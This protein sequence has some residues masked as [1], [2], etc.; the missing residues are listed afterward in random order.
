[1]LLREAA[2]AA[3]A[4]EARLL[5]QS[6]ARESVSLAAMRLAEGKIEEADALLLKTP[7]ASIEPSREAA[8]VF[9]ALGDWNAIRQRTRLAADCYS[10][11]LQANRLDKSVLSSSTMMSVLAVGP[12]L[13]E[14]GSFAEYERFRDEA[15]ARNEKTADP[16]LI[17]SLL[18]ASLLTPAE[19]RLLA[20]LRP[21]TE[22]LTAVLTVPNHPQAQGAYQSAFSALSLAMMAYRAGDFNGALEWCAKGEAYPDANQARSA[23]IHAVAAMAARKL[24]RPEQARLELARARAIFAGPFNRDVMYPR[25]E[26]NGVWFDW[27]IARVLEREAAG[28]LGEVAP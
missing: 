7:P 18:K 19:D 14:A 23:A 2:D 3:R 13:V 22:K 1:M 26:G 15:I 6:K 21:A 9:L 20:R 24:D 11:F 10:L 8:G 28:L 16:M 25:G 27:V 17:A 4:N 5:Q 12:T